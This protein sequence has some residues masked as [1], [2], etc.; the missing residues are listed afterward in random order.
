MTIFFSIPKDETT[1][2]QWTEQIRAKTKQE[3]IFPVEAMVCSKHFEKSL[4][5]ERVN[6][7]RVLLKNS[8]PTIFP[9]EHQEP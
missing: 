7:S 4:F 3:N 2:K 6:G 5:I 9:N 1:R 8:L